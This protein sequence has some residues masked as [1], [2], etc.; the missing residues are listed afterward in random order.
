MMRTSLSIVRL[1]LPILLAV[2][3]IGWLSAQ[4]AKLADQYY[5]EGEYAKAADLYLKLHETAK[6]TNNF[7]YF[8]KYVECLLA[9]RSFDR[10][11]RE[12]REQMTLQPD[13]YSLLVTLGNVQ[14]RVGRYED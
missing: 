10:A 8:N 7:T 1:L 9:M 14:E 3:P 11:E 13:D 5:L 2:S 6:K 4:N 12:I